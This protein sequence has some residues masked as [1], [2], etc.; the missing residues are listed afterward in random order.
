VELFRE[1]LALR[2][3]LGEP[4]GI[5]ASLEALGAVAA[6]TGD[7][8]GA[9]RLLGAAEAARAQIGV[10]RW[11]LGADRVRTIEASATAELGEEGFRLAREA[12]QALSVEAALVI[13][14]GVDPALPKTD[15]DQLRR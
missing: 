5:A 6:A 8:E 11:A 10:P 4:R 13:A 1:S 7:A 14:L 3:E 9:A 12:G 2:R 15:E